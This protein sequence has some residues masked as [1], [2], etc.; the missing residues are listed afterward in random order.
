MKGSFQSGEKDGMTDAVKWGT[1]VEEYEN[2]E[3]SGV[4]G[5]EEVSFS[6]VR[7]E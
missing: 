7:V 4:R 1:E 2:V 3:V 5:E 6:T